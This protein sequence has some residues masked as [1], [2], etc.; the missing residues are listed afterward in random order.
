MELPA[1]NWWL[2]KPISICVCIWWFFMCIKIGREWGDRSR[3]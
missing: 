1:I 2:V 3:W